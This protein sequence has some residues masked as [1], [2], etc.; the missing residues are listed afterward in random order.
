MEEAQVE[1]VQTPEIPEGSDVAVPEG[2]PTVK[3]VDGQDVFD[4]VVFMRECK[5]ANVLV[6]LATLG[7]QI[8]YAAR[9]RLERLANDS[10]PPEHVPQVVDYLVQ[11]SRARALTPFSLEEVRVQLETFGI[12]AVR[13]LEQDAKELAAKDAAAAEAKKAE[14]NESS[15]SD[16]VDGGGVETGAVDAAAGEVVHETGVDS[17]ADSGA[18]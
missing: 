8:Y 3:L 6:V 10:V 4:P 17:V 15:D 13:L 18:A 14:D 1:P 7:W 5:S 2:V 9:H 12:T 16:R 11:A